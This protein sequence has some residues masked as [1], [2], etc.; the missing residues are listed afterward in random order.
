MLNSI[1]NKYSL[2]LLLLSSGH[3]GDY[4]TK[5]HNWWVTWER[6]HR[7]LGILL[8]EVSRMMLCITNYKVL[9]RDTQRCLYWLIVISNL[10]HLHSHYTFLLTKLI[11]TKALCRFKLCTLF[12]SCSK[13]EK[14][15]SIFRIIIEILLT[16]YTFFYASACTLN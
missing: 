12:Y 13:I 9:P 8:I 10:L 1:C 14:H 11:C 6:L 4:F 15:Y 2:F 7:G 3:M 5:F 16:F